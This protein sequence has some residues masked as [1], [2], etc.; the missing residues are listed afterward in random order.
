MSGSTK[1][2]KFY[3]N[4]RKCK[5][6]VRYCEFESCIPDGPA[7]FCEIDTNK[8]CHS[9]NGYSREC[10]PESNNPGDIC[11]S[12]ND[13]K[14]KNGV[15]LFQRCLFT[16][17]SNDLTSSPTEEYT[18][19]PTVIYTDYPTDIP[20]STPTNNLTIK[21]T[22]NPTRTKTGSPTKTYTDSPITGSPTYSLT[23]SLS[24]SPTSSP[25]SQPTITASPTIEEALLSDKLF[26]PL[27]PTYTNYISENGEYSFTF[28]LSSLPYFD[29]SLDD[30]EEFMFQ[31]QMSY[32]NT[33]SNCTWSIKVETRGHIY[34]FEGPFG[35]S[36]LPNTKTGMQFVVKVN[37]KV[38]I[39]S[40]KNRD[41]NG[42]GYFMYQS[43]V[44]QNGDPGYT[45]IKPF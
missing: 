15:C 41:A 29:D 37:H 24:D 25:V 17:R 36:I 22:D 42:G 14:G 18:P 13:C 6:R 31:I 32:T 44:Y 9:D 23:S 39:D 45:N 12:N 8:L 30:V 28:N 20:T 16:S 7:D 19:S 33:N 11:D 34:S 1:A 35:K 21:Q 43:N 5:G 38:C 4:D 40:A 2:G 10:A 26:S 3:K 27:S